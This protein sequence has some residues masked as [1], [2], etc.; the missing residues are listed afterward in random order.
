MKT[1]MAVVA[2]GLGACMALPAAEENMGQKASG[3]LTARVQDLHLTDAQEAKIAD[4]RKEYGP[5]VREAAKNLATVVKE[6]EEKVMDVLTAEQKTKLRDTK[7]ELKEMRAES[8]AEEIAH[9]GEL[10]LTGNE[11]SQIASIRKEYRP[12]IEESLTELEGLLTPDQKK[13]R[14]D[15][16]QAGKQG[17]VVRE[18]LKLTNEAK[19]KVQ[20]VGKKVGTW[21]REEMERIRDVLSSGQKKQLQEV[22]EETKEHVRDRM[23]HRIA[24]LKELNLTEDQKTRI[25]AIRKEFGPRVHEAG[26]RLRA[27][28]REEVEAILAVIKG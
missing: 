3:G 28:I 5:R 1:L 26:N 8:L 20:A 11:I 23:A 14:Q 6:E 18:A 25:A 9:L 10:D 16:L 13:A 4:I 2:L 15:A 19:E 21:C 22:K 7:E 24:T 12:K 27:T 17:R